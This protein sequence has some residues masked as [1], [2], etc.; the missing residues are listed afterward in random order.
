MKYGSM[1]LMQFAKTI[2]LKQYYE[3]IGI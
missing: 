3:L 1:P 2:T